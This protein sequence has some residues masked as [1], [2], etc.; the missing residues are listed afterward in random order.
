ME[1]SLGISYP[2]VKTHLANL[3]KKLLVA[4]E[5]TSPEKNSK[6]QTESQED[7]DSLLTLSQLE[8]GEIGFKKAI[9]L[10]RVKKKEK[11]K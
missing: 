3:K 8:N 10:L 9:Q 1:A 4:G 2:T 6:G 5:K 7:K 11:E